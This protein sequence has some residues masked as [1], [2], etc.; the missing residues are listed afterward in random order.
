MQP[1]FPEYWYACADAEYNSDNKDV[2]LQHYVKVTQ[3]EPKNYEAW[4]DYGDTLIEVGNYKE[5]IFALEQ[6][7]KLN[8]KFGLSH[9][10]RAKALAGL[11]RFEE[12]ANEFSASFIISPELRSEFLSIF[13]KLA[14]WRWFMKLI[15]R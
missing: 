3:L 10:S 2:A 4:F 5:G 13:P 15:N 8:E 12:A 7:I 14:S 6:S 11:N 9:F 1:S